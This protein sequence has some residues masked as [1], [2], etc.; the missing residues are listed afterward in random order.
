MNKK[1]YNFVKYGISQDL[2]TELISKDLNITTLKNT[3]IKNLT[4][5]YNIDKIIATEIKNLVTRNPIDKTVLNELLINNNFTCC[6]CLGDKG[7]TFIVHHIEEYEISQDNSYDNL[8]VLCPTCHDLAHAPR[9][10][11]LSITKEQLINAK[12]TWEDNCKKKRNSSTVQPIKPIVESWIGEFQNNL[13]DVCLEYLFDLG[14]WISK[15]EIYGHFTITYLNRGN[16]FMAGE[17]RHQADVVDADI[18]ITYWGMQW[19][20]RVTEK[21]TSKAIINYGFHDEIHI[22]NFTSEDEILPYDLKLVK[23][24]LET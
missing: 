16:M 11:T 10:L 12:N 6:C 18:E 9:L 4:D 20:M 23:Q 21:K 14:L 8:A 19:G 24:P 15:D 5:K 2:A 7:L 3:S 1:M 13:D 22:I 17:F